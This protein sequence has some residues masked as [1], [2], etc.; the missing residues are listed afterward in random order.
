VRFFLNHL[1]C[2]CS[3]L[4][5]RS[6]LATVNGHVAAAVRATATFSSFLSSSRQESMQRAAALV[7]TRQN[8]L[9]SRTFP[10][11]QQHHHHYHHQ[12]QQQQQQFVSLQQCQPP[13]SVWPASTETPKKE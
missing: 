1:I 13:A 4:L 3:L 7:L 8:A 2:F 12:Q 9:V 5:F 11:G 10:I 6:G